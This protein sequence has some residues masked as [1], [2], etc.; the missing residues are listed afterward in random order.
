M[1]L[2]LNDWDYGRFKDKTQLEPWVSGGLFS[3]MRNLK[4][5]YSNHI[6]SREYVKPD[7]QS[8]S[9]VIIIVDKME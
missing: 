7:G 2:G 5:S 9:K 4:R 6:I 1:K 8:M 3:E